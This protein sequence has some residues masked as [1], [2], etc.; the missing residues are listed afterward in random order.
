MT[1][2]IPGCR[3]L[4]ASAVFSKSSLAVCP[5]DR[6]GPRTS[7]WRKRT[8][9]YP[10][11]LWRPKSVRSPALQSERHR[12]TVVN[13]VSPSERPQFVHLTDGSSTGHRWNS[14]LSTQHRLV[15][16]GDGECTGE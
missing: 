9:I 6:Q 3:V 1:W 12:A 13:R 11:Q 16:H 7:A 8:A 2:A 5:R 15:E 10:R 4:G 14:H